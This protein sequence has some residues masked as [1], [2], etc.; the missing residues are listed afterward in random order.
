MP[1][2]AGL[3]DDKPITADRVYPDGK[4]LALILSALYLAVFVVSL[5]G[6]WN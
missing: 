2:P 5:V 3:G 6:Y 4:K 1:G